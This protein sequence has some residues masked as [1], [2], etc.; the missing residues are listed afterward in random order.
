MKLI[1]EMQASTKVELEVLLHYVHDFLA[2]NRVD[3]LN[4][5]GFST[6]FGTVTFKLSDE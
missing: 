6:D 2:N 5:Q 1:V 3:D 4:Y